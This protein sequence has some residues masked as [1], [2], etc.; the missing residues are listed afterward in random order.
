MIKSVVKI[1]S[2]PF[3]GTY[4]IASFKAFK[5]SSH[6]LQSVSLQKT[7]EVPTKICKFQQLLVAVYPD[8]Q[9]D[10]NVVPQTIDKMS[11]RLDILTAITNRMCTYK[12]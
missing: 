7:L 6:F 5:D 3:Q 1:Y 9:Q 4:K 8:S 2:H 11:D 10:L 12:C